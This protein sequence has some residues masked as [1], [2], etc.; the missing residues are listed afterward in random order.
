MSNRA[1]LAINQNYTIMKKTRL[2]S[3]YVI[4]QNDVFIM[5]WQIKCA[6]KLVESNNESFSHLYELLEK[7]SQDIQIQTGEKCYTISECVQMREATINDMVSE[8][9]NRAFEEAKAD[10]MRR[11]RE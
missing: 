2:Q 8:E 5:L 7:Y 11:E 3:Q 10:R 9:N 6:A 1:T 4:P